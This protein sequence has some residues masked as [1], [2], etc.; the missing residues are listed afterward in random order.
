LSR[1]GS[2][3]PD[4]HAS[5]SCRERRR[6]W[7]RPGSTWTTEKKDSPWPLFG[8]G[9]PDLQVRLSFSLGSNSYSLSPTATALTYAPGQL[10]IVE[11]DFSY[12]QTSGGQPANA[13]SVNATIQIPSTARAS[14]YPSSGAY[15][16]VNGD[17]SS[18]CATLNVAFISATQITLSCGG[19]T[20]TKNWIDPDVAMAF[21]ALTNWCSD[22]ELRKPPSAV[23]LTVCLREVPGGIQEMAD[24]A[25]FLQ[26]R[27]DT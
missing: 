7:R 16:V 25:V 9:T 12:D 2:E 8:G 14:G 6:R 20:Y 17:S 11:D 21:A 3:L 23:T 19:Q 24:A 5:L 4:S 10:S 22:S 18:P 1:N 13:V 15:A 26:P 27:P